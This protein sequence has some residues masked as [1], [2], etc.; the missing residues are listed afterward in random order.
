MAHIAL[1]LGAPGI[2]GPMRAYP[3][4][5]RALNA[6]AQALLR[7]PS[8]LSAGE[9]ELIGAFVSARN[10][11]RFCFGAHAATACHLGVG[12][13]ADLA[14]VVEDPTTAPISKKLRALLAIA[15]K[16]RRDGRLVDDADVAA[17]RV[18]GADDQAIHDTVLIAAAFSMF[19]RYVDGLATSALESDAEYEPIGRTLAA[20]GY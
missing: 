13:A 5:G 20:G 11:C 8:S 7:G 4:T 19:N 2:V 10:G 18:Q 1:P 9:R 16:V 12:T 14:R 3:E 15:E 17:A 6:L